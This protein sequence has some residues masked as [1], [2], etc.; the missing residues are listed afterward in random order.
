MVALAERA[1]TNL[2]PSARSALLD[3]TS[4]RIW[5]AGADTHER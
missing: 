3:G 1:C 5:F 2:S 4:R